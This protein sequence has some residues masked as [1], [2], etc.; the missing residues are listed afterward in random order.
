M[1]H[2]DSNTLGCIPHGSAWLPAHPLAYYFAKGTIGRNW[3]H[4]GIMWLYIGNKREQFGKLLLQPTTPE[5]TN[6]TIKRTLHIVRN[7]PKNCTK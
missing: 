5:N 1:G 6:P 2:I 7:R 4:C 3:E